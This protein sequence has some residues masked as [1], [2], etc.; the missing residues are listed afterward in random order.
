LS[1][2]WHDKGRTEDCC[3]GDFEHAVHS[4]VFSPDTWMKKQSATCARRE[5]MPH[6]L[7]DP[8]NF[9]EFPVRPSQEIILYFGPATHPAFQPVVTSRD[10]A[11]A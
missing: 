9:L 4:F 5:K 7:G 1:S 6:R 2:S 3:Q 8:T 11:T 10:N